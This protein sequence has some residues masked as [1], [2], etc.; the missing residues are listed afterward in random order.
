MFLIY[1]RH[2]QN[3]SIMAILRYFFILTFVS[4]HTAYSILGS[5]LGSK[6]VIYY[7]FSPFIF[8]ITIL[9]SKLG[10]VVLK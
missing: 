3:R 10:G 9:E 2:T 4:L 8:F 7:I 5:V 1:F 6:S